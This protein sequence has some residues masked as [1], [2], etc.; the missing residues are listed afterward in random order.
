MR[1]LQA[2]RVANASGKRKETE[3]E[4]Y[5]KIDRMVKAQEGTL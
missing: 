2:V 3:W 4:I 5:K 1:R